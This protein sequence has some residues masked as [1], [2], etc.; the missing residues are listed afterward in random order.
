MSSSPPS[1]A[2]NAHC[3][4]LGPRQRFPFAA[5]AAFIPAEDAPREALYALNDRLGLARC[6]VVQSTCHGFDNRAT[7]D[8]VA[9]RSDNYRGIALLPCDV[10]DA[11]LRRLDTAGFRGVRFNYMS[12]LG[13]CVPITEVLRLAGRLVPLGWHLQIHGDPVLLTELAEPLRR[14]PVPVVSTISAASTRRRVRSRP[15][16][17]PCCG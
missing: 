11:E 5:N 14:S 16:I 6:V 2:C 17:W 15:T 10:A 12:H 8:A 7:E 1:L 9:G 4:V 3:H 13:Q